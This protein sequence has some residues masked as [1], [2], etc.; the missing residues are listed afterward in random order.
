MEVHM[1]ILFRPFHTLWGT[2]E[3]RELK[4]GN[5]AIASP[6][7]EASHYAKEALREYEL[8][9]YVSCSRTL[10]IF[11]LY[12]LYTYLEDEV[13]FQGWGIDKQPLY[14]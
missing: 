14:D 7:P 11:S 13:K 5:P 6:L 8:Q 1:V 10:G 9:L 3:T 12:R 4:E 2:H